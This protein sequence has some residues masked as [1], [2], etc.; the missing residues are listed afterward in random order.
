MTTMT[1]TS[2]GS[3]KVGSVFRRHVIAPLVVALT[4]GALLVAP[5]LTG[6]S[7]PTASAACPAVEV[8]FARGRTEA[9]GAGVIGNNFVSALRSKTD[10]NVSLYS[11]QYPADNEIDVGANDMSRRVQATA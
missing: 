7:V 9:P 2:T 10:R 8:I 5:V 3:T 4:A 11:V 6:H 1:S